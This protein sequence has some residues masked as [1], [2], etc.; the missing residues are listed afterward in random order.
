[1]ME[2]HPPR[3]ASPPDGVAGEMRGRFYGIGGLQLDAGTS[4]PAL[5]A[6]PAGEPTYSTFA[7]VRRAIAPGF[8]CEAD[9]IVVTHGTTDGLCRVL[10]GLELRAGDEIVTTT[11]EHPGGLAPLALLRDR[12]GVVVRR[13]PLPVGSGQ[14][15][16]EHVER[17]AAAITPQT[18]VLFFSAPTWNTGTLLPIRMLAGLA[19]AHGLVSVVDG[20]HLPGMLH[21]DFHALGVDFLAGSGT[22]WQFGPADT[23]LLY[24][25]NRVLP[26]QNST[27][28]PPFWPVITIWYPTEGGLPPRA[29]GTRPAYDIAELLQTTGA[30]GAAR[31]RG[32]ERACRTWDAVGRGRI[33]RHLLEL[34]GHLRER[35]AARWGEA[36]LYSPH[37]DPRLASAIVAFTPFGP[38][39]AHDRERTAGLAARLAEEHGVVVRAVPVAVEGSPAPH[40]ALRV[41]VRPFHEHDDVDR[42]L[43]AVEAAVRE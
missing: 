24:V 43:R 18:R 35:V 15:A 26:G 25:R 3:Q 38:E 23:G 34:A 14:R 39:H 32:F 17:F 29:R 37:Q 20:A 1:M 42:L 16:E 10:A 8:G 33:E 31:V 11:H 22:K 12:T 27:E 6:V 5:A 2:P 28:P 4:G 21:A 13:V 40:Q 19:Q 30:T 36:A 7:E 41:S 9:E